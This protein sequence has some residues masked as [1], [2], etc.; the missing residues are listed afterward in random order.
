M[1]SQTRNRKAN[2]LSV[3]KN[4]EISQTSI[5]IKPE[6]LKGIMPKILYV[7]RNIEVEKIGVHPNREGKHLRFED[8]L[9]EVVDGYL[10][11]LGII[12]KIRGLSGTHSPAFDQNGRYKPS[13]FIQATFVFVDVE[14]GEEWPIE[15]SGEGSSVGGSDSTRVAHTMLAKIAYLE[16]FK[17]RENNASRYDSD[18]VATQIPDAEPLPPQKSE[19]EKATAESVKELNAQVKVFIDGGIPAKTVSTEG[20]AISDDILEPGKK[21]AEWKKDPRVLEELVEKL[22]TIAAT[23]EVS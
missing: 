15:V 4:A 17:I 5:E 21:M 11:K 1:A 3:N 9:A 2:T 19:S 13:A 23:G 22:K 20:Q 10:N 6:E 14:T 7:Q 12:T 18:D 16:T 8:V